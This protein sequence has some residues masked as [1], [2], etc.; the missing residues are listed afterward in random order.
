[1]ARNVKREAV[2]GVIASLKA[3][4]KEAEERPT[5]D[6]SDFW[7]S[8]GQERAYEEAIWIVEELLK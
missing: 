4:Q 7:S 2:E 8:V 3:K 6:D 1:M 5:W